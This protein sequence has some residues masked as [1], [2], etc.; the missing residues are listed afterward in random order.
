[1]WLWRRRKRACKALGAA[2]EPVHLDLDALRSVDGKLGVALS[3]GGDSLALLHLLKEQTSLD[4]YAVTFDHGL[5]TTSAAEALTAGEMCAAI[6]VPHH[7]LRWEP[8][9]LKGNMQDAARTARRAGISAW[10]RERGIG[11]VALGHTADDQAETFLM[12]LARGSGVDGLS[13]M[14]TVIEAAGIAWLRPLLHVRRED[15]RDYLT[16]KGLTWVDD[17]S[18]TDRGFERVRVRQALGTL[19]DLGIDVPKIAK[20]TR[21]LKSA[22]QVLY[23]ATKD[24]GLAISN[25]TP[26]G[27]LTLE[28]DR[29]LSAQ[30][31]LRLRLLSDAVRFVAGSYYAPRS[32][33]V[34]GVLEALEGKMA[35]RSLHGC[36]VTAPDDVIH[37]RREPA[38]C[39]DAVPLGQ[40]WDGRWMVHG[41]DAGAYRVGA[42]S[43]AGLAARPN[44]REAGAV[45]SV[46]LTTPG[47][48]DGDDLVAAPLLESA[49]EWQAEI[50]LRNDFFTQ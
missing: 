10:A 19:G 21:R 50:C 32:Y 11:A 31:A 40:V 16:A 28:R 35:G 45:R 15:L 24:L 49:G 36:L 7:I 26:F 46:L 9:D 2:D 33:M 1:M 12:R 42:L 37:I 3:G 43:E 8:E 17:P 38:A 25:L 48:W 4:L 5:R 30:P 13:A 20:T 14:D 23:T 29:L 47:V 34:Q 44:W 39:E 41:P 18:N 27:E 22:K 6:G